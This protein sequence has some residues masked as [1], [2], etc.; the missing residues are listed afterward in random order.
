MYGSDG[1]PYLHVMM[2]KRPLKILY[3]DGSSAVLSETGTLDSQ[4]VLLNHEILTD[5]MDPYIYNETARAKEL[6]K[7]AGQLQIDGIVRMN[8]GFEILVCNLEKAG[9]QELYTINATLPGQWRLDINQTLPRDSN[10]RPPH[11]YGSWY[12]EQNVWEWVRSATWHY[13]GSVIGSTGERRV[14]LDL[15]AFITFYDRSLQSLSHSCPS[16]LQASHRSH[17][18]P[19]LRAGHRLLGIARHDIEKLHGWIK[20]ATASFSSSTT[21]KCSG[22][23]WQVLTETI[24]NVH[25]TRLREMRALFRQ[26]DSGVLKPKQILA[27][28]HELSHAALYPFLE[29]PET[30][31]QSLKQTKELALK[32]CRALYIAYVDQFS[33]NRFEQVIHGAIDEVLGTLCSLQWELFEWSESRTTAQLDSYVESNSLSAE[34]LREEIS[35]HRKETDDVVS[36][37]GWNRPVECAKRCE[38]NVSLQS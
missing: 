6:C 17:G 9:L 34:Q 20:E 31:G 21:R 33:M 26:L 13:G 1:A 36:W 18:A 4:L 22:I 23:D 32:R 11:G 16:S 35:R 10:R 5:L 37:L 2:T 7:F 30:S 19:G 29:Y 15:C 8:A 3:M 28:V 14:H 25:G 38:W 12:S 27:K 24:T